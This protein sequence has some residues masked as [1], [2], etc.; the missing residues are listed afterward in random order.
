MRTMTQRATMVTL[1]IAAT[2][3]ATIGVQAAAQ[4]DEPIRLPVAE[5]LELKEGEGRDT[6]VNNCLKCHTMKPIITHDGLTDEAWASEVDK[7]R[8]RY[9]AQITDEDAEVI[10]TYLQTYYSDQPPAADDVLLFGLDNAY[11]TPR[12]GEAEAGAS[13]VATPAQQASD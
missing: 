1:L 5:G 4:D 8:T 11:A 13:P 6:V 9:G 10:V 3:L 12:A 2:I 7:M